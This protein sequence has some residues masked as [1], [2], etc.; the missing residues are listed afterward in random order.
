M[1]H[2]IDDY[3]DLNSNLF[4]L[5]LIIV[6]DIGSIDDVNVDSFD[7]KDYEDILRTEGISFYF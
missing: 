2:I 1:D 6:G 4:L 5:H 3:G 7:L